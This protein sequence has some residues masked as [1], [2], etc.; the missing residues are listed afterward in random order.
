MASS[1]ALRLKRTRRPGSAHDE[2]FTARISSQD[3]TL[4]QR[5]AE[6]SGVSLSSYVFSKARTAAIADLADAGEVVL[7]PAD[8]RRFVELLLAPPKPNGALR[9]VLKVAKRVPRGW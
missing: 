2:R 7:A 8:R 6:R 4:L 5:A 3:K 9:R 1:R